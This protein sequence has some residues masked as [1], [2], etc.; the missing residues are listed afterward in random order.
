MPR[1]VSQITIQAQG[2]GGRDAGGT[3]GRGAFVRAVIP[4]SGGQVLTVKVGCQDGWGFAAGGAGGHN[5]DQNGVNGGG[6]TGVAVGGDPVIVAGGGGGGAG[7]GIYYTCFNNPCDGGIAASSTLAAGAGGDAFLPPDSA[8]ASSGG[9]GAG[10]GGAPPGNGRHGHLRRRYQLAPIRATSTPVL[11]VVAAA[12]MT[13][14][15]MAAAAAAPTGLQYNE[16][17]G[18]LAF[19]GHGAGG[20]GGGGA[21]YFAPLA[22][23]RSS[24]LVPTRTD[25]KLTITL[26]ARPR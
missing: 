18:R 8:A 7:N 26:P 3:G 4:V 17:N 22:S 24:Q 2:A 11:A 15:A 21:S 16:T 14:P 25:G 1:D 12:A 20:G 23:N 19:D 10:A 5:A 13:G 9:A 6:A